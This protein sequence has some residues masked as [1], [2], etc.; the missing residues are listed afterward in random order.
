MEFKTVGVVG[1][2]LM[3]AGIT[4][5]CAQTG[6]KVIVSEI[7]DA[8]LQKGL[9]SIDAQLTRSVDKG[10]I[11]PEDKTAI[12]GRIK[13]TTNMADFAPCDI[14]IEAATED[15]N[16]KKSIFGQLDKYCK[17][18]A[19]LATNT[20]VL[21]VAEIAGATKRPE[22]VL[23]MHFAQPVPVTKILEMVR[24]IAN[25]DDIVAAGKAFGE[26]I[27]KIV[28]VTKDLPGFISNRLFSSFVLNAVRLVQEGIATPKDIDT[29]FKYGSNH[30][31]GPLETLDFVGLDT[32]YNGAKAMYEELHDPQYA[33]PPLL[34]RM[35]K[36]G[37]LGRKSGKGFYD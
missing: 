15:M 2:G 13:G 31:M 28:V 20:S 21:C 18:G 35:V 17:S 36:L 10:R 3:G 30:P 4:Q 16:I 24:T 34:A 7:N 19:L 5:L 1:C 11:K 29:V 25:N 6:Y 27:G 8:A 14:V 22:N 37:W 33:P 32:V 26:S 12:M 9:K 23:G